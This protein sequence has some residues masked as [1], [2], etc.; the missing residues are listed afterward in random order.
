MFFFFT[1]ICL[2]FVI[3]KRGTHIFSQFSMFAA[4]FFVH[5][6]LIHQLNWVKKTQFLSEGSRAH[7]TLQLLLCL[8]LE[9]LTLQASQKWKLCIQYYDTQKFVILRCATC[10]ESFH[11]C[12]V[13]QNFWMCAKSV[14]KRKISKIYARLAKT[15]RKFRVGGTQ[16]FRFFLCANF[17]GPWNIRQ[18]H[19]WLTLWHMHT[20]ICTLLWHWCVCH[21]LV[22]T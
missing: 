10:D 2:R 3:W 17:R 9:E 16:S 18:Q 20:L 19:V 1:F 22:S 12:A 4:L 13:A 15:A 8:K 21:P 7:G 11:F 5:F 14:Q 6:F